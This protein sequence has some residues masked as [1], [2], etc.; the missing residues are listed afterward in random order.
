MKAVT[1]GLVLFLVM[2]CASCGGRVGTQIGFGRCILVDLGIE[3]VEN[4]MSSVH[5]LRSFSFIAAGESGERYYRG[6]YG[7]ANL[8][9]EL[10]DVQQSTKVYVKSHSSLDDVNSVMGLI[11]AQLRRSNVEFARADFDR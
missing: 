8:F 9:F 5:G 3:Q 7:E 4:E 2:V 1:F 10:V 11:Q 6:M